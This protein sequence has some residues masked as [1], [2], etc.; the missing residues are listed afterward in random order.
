[1]WIGVVIAAAALTRA[2]SIIL[3]PLLGLPLVWRGDGGTPARLRRLGAVAAAT[4]VPLLPW[5]VY[6]MS[7][8]DA[9]AY[10]STGAGGTFADSSCDGVF[11]GPNIGWWQNNCIPPD[12]A[13]DESQRDSAL[14]HLA[15][16]YVG[17]HKQQLPLVV[18][19]RVGRMWEVFRP[20]QTAGLD[21]IEGRGRFAGW[22]GL[23]TYL[24]L[25]PLAIAGAFVMYA[26]GRPLLPLIAIVVTVTLTAALFYG[27]L[28]FR[29]PADVVLIILAAVTIDTAASTA[30]IGSAPMRNR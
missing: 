13:G 27:A 18:G 28:R 1:V 10:L 17:H 24:A 25:L 8:F 20:V 6:N 2:E 3:L 23:I 14:R 29:V 26:R 12:I 9:P 5:V 16:T 4:I 11:Y 21:W 15:F 19:A 7:R 30:S 22:S